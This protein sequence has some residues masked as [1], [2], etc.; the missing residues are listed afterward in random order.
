MSQ[1]I[2]QVNGP[3]RN[4]TAPV[5]SM[6]KG[7]SVVD[8]AEYLSADRDI[9]DSRVKNK[10]ISLIKEELEKNITSGLWDED[11]PDDWVDEIDISYDGPHININ[12]SKKIKAHEEGVDPH[13]M[14]YLY[15]KVVPIETDQ[16][17]NDRPVFRKVTPKSLAEGKW[18][19]SGM[20]GKGFIQ[21]AVDTALDRAD[22]IIKEM[23]S[24]EK[25]RQGEL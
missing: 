11:L 6:A 12:Y 23:H 21:D 16:N 20:A 14:N 13:P 1:R 7:Y 18:F 10:I 19:H 24:I 2:N 22:E 5:M 8:A 15:G 25:D 4:S 17:G 9:V 3:P